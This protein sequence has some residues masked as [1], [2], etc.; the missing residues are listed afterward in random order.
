MADK[1]VFGTVL[2]LSVIAAA[3]AVIYVQREEIGRLINEVSD[4]FFSETEAPEGT[5]AA[6]PAEKD[7]VIDATGK[8]LRET[9]EEIAEA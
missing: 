9:V 2:K 8:S 6:E 1:S 4:R 3:A 7:I 5:D